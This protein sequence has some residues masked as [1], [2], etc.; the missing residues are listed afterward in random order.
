M[1]KVLLAALP[2]AIDSSP[3][4]SS[5]EWRT[6]F[7]AAGI[8]TYDDWN[9]IR[10]SATHRQVWI[11]AGEPSANAFIEAHLDGIAATLAHIC[12]GPVPLEI[13]DRAIGVRACT[14]K[15]WAYRIP[16]LVVEKK[17]GDWSAHFKALLDPSLRS[18]IERKVER[19]IRRELDMWGRLPHALDNDAPFLVLSQPGR[20]MPIPAITSQRSGH[21][22]PVNVLTRLQPVFLSYWRLEGQIF[23][24][25]LAS[26]GYGRIARTEAP[27]LIDRATQKTLLDII[28]SQPESEAAL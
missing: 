18:S 28:P 4:R 24:G 14:D 27:E 8:G 17:A 10:V 19:S 2:P 13:S 9:K 21:G 25:P 1:Q 26:L 11:V 23:V 12:N 5:S 22:K 3:E 16:K 6:A 20:A 15:L 7:V